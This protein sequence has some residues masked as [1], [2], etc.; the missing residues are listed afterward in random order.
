MSQGNYSGALE[1][2][3]PLPMRIRAKLFAIETDNI[4]NLKLPVGLTLLEYLNS[5]TIV[6][7]YILFELY[8]WLRTGRESPKTAAAAAIR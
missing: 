7:E 8:L 1:S 4:Q 3:T 6:F 2:I 5:V